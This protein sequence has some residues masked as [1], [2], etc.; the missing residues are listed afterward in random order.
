MQA[1]D[2]WS[3]QPTLSARELL[4]ALANIPDEN[5]DLPVMTE[6]CD[7]DGNVRMVE[8]DLEYGRVYLERPK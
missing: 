2:P 7:C 6:G 8:L 1:L 3:K 4:E 5:L